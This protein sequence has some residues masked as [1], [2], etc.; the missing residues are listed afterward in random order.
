MQIYIPC[1]NLFIFPTLIFKKKA[2]PVSPL[3]SAKIVAVCCL[4]SNINYFL[5]N[6]CSLSGGQRKG[7]GDIYLYFGCRK[8]SVDNIY[9]QELEQAKQDGVIKEVYIA[10]SREPDHPKVNNDISKLYK[11]ALEN[12]TTTSKSNLKTI[13]KNFND[14]NNTNRYNTVYHL[15]LCFMMRKYT[16]RL[17]F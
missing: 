4:T 14:N 2:P 10:L 13:L 16:H 3:N 11:I 6:T 1:T 5:K 7:W 9:Q 17:R 12:T 15:K 8:S